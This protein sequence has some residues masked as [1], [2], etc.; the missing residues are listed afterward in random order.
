MSLR[1][2]L[3]SEGHPSLFHLVNQLLRAFSF[4]STTILLPKYF[5]GSLGRYPETP[6]NVYVESLSTFFHIMNPSTFWRWNSHPVIIIL[7]LLTWPPTFTRFRSYWDRGYCSD[8]DC[9][10]SFACFIF[11]DPPLRSVQYEFMN[12][13]WAR[14]VGETI[15]G[16]YG[17]WSSFS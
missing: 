1:R 5:Q 13:T 9:W 8:T 3:H 2:I 4:L 17:M 11:T 12:L 6:V 14:S 7:T 10:Y 16:W 15:P